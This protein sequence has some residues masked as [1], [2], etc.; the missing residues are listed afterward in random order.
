MNK[1]KVKKIDMICRCGHSQSSN[2]DKK[3]RFTYSVLLR[4]KG[5]GVGFSGMYGN[6][7]YAKEEAKKLKGKVIRYKNNP[8]GSVTVTGK[9]VTLRGKIMIGA[10][11]KVVC[12]KCWRFK[13]NHDNAK[14]PYP[15]YHIANENHWNWKTIKRVNNL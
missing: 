4:R 14:C 10:T 8:D 5:L 12:D 3:D 11:G 1:K 6:L 7:R 2:R 13:T 15:D 9:Y